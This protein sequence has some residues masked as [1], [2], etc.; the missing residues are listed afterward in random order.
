MPASWRTDCH[1]VGSRS[2]AGARRIAVGVTAQ[3]RDSIQR[4]FV[5]HLLPAQG[6]GVPCAAGINDRR[7]THKMC[8]MIVLEASCMTT[9]PRS[10]RQLCRGVWTRCLASSRERDDTSSESPALERSGMMAGLRGT[11]SNPSQQA[12]E[13]S[14][15]V[16]DQHLAVGH[17]Q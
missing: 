4:H 2:A 14:A 11:G 15:G 6:L 17:R 10:Q 5:C 13:P 16:S 9:E 7:V 12:T 1:K 8:C 3:T